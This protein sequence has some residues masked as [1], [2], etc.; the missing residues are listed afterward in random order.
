MKLFLPA[1]HVLGYALLALAGI[2]ILP[3][4][5]SLALESGDTR[6]FLVAMLASLLSALVILGYCRWWGAGG[7]LQPRQMFLVTVLVW[8]VVPLYASLPFLLIEHGLT[9]TDAV[10]ETVSGMTTTGSTVMTG[11]DQMPLDVLL[12]RSCLQWFGGIGIITLAVAVLPFLRVGGMRLF[13]T[14][15]SEWS[16]RG[17]L[18]AHGL[19]KRMLLAYFLLTATCAAVYLML[20]MD[21]F[22]AINHA[23]TS[24]STGGYSTSDASFGQ[25]GS[26]SLTWAATLFM[27]AGGIPFGVYVHAMQ[28]RDI[29]VFSDTQIRTFITIIFLVALTLSLRMAGDFGNADWWLRFSHAAFNVTSVITTTGYASTDYSLWGGFAI[30]VFFFITFLGGCSGS[31]SGG[32]KIFRVQLSLMLIRDQV[33]RAIHPKVVLRRQYNGHPV[34]DEVYSSLIAFLFLLAL[35]WVVISLLMALSGLDIITSL[36]GAATALMN[37]G[38]G[39]GSIIGPAGTFQDIPDFAKWVLCAGMILGRLEFMAV[40]VVFSRRYWVN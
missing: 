29:G 14:E 33:V 13:R 21:V 5:L 2:M 38:P 23:M 6:A 32:V 36:S 24:I 17:R 39:L 27:I 15:S 30:L 3:L 18:R 35:S 19:L 10:F 31:T 12:W 1:F 40:L 20:G 8:L 37:V 7:A 26:L 11:L 16:D 22:N 4:V 34:N 28:E 25:F 9:V